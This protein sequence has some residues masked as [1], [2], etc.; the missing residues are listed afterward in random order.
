MFN[1]KH[2]RTEKRNLEVVKNYYNTSSAPYRILELIFAIRYSSNRVAKFMLSELIRD[3]ISPAVVAKMICVA[4][5]FDNLEF[6]QHCRAMGLVE[7]FEWINMAAEEG[8]LRIVKWLHENG[9][10]GTARAMDSAALNGHLQVVIW[11]HENRPEGC[12]HRALETPHYDIK[13]WLMRHVYGL[14]P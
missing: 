4:I 7:D 9:F 12:S 2:H 11:L 10:R 1:S 5:A 13:I 14:I 3:N 8:Q 6:L